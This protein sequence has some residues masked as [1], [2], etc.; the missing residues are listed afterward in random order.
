M[1]ITRDPDAMR[2]FAG[3]LSGFEETIN[4]L[5]IS[6]E[7]LLQDAET[8]MQ[9]EQ[10]RRVVAVIIEII[11][12]V[13]KGLPGIEENRNRLVKSASYLEEAQQIHF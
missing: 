10:G 2:A 9:D 13:R 4:S 7:R 5:C 3:D 12:M 1:K 8:C 11:Q 6:Y